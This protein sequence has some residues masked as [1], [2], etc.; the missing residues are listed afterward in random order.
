VPGVALSSTVM[1]CA[2]IRPCANTPRP[3]PA[4]C[5]GAT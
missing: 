2:A 4:C 5:A 1:L 3:I